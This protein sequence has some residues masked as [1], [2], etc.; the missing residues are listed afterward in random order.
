MSS[1]SVEQHD[2]IE[3][4]LNGDLSDGARTEFERQLRSDADLARQL[5]AEQHIRTALGNDAVR[6]PA[7]AT[8][9]SAA[10]V[11]ALSENGPGA[12]SGSGGPGTGVLRTIFGT[13]TG[14]AVLVSA[15]LIG[16]LIGALIVADPFSRS[17]LPHQSTD[18]PSGVAAPGQDAEESASI[19]PQKDIEPT[20]SD[21]SA[22]R[23]AA[24]TR[25]AVASSVSTTS[26]TEPDTTKSLS[27][28]SED[29]RT[30]PDAAERQRDERAKAL[31]RQLQSSGEEKTVVVRDDSVDLKLDVEE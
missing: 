25:S 7:A 9:P 1:N 18:L 30:I 15:G 2:M 23:R 3:R 5:R 19:H 13:G 14:L 20:P 27:D 26:P 12:V 16:L 17:E 22:N 29:M 31:A 8:E 10:L 4:Y 24:P 6:I 21:T 28:R 11:T